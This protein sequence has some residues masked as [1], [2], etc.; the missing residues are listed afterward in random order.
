MCAPPLVAVEWLVAAEY[1]WQCDSF[2]LEQC[3]GTWQQ[4]PAAF[5][6][7]DAERICFGSGIGDLDGCS[8]FIKSKM[9]GF[10]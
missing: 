1:S 9:Y 3:L 4:F 6:E 2:L 8:V 10:F 5:R 7:Y